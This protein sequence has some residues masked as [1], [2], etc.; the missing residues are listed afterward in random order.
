ML[1]TN[2]T[3]QTQDEKLAAKLARKERRKHGHDEEDES[4]VSSAILGF[5]QE[6]LRKA[7]EEQLRSNASMPL[8][9]SQQVRVL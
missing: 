5:D 6:D 1:G 3:V 2:F 8:A 9:S 4:A 7:R